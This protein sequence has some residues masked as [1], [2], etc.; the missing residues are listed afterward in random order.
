[1]SLHPSL[2]KLEEFRGQFPTLA[3]FLGAWFPD[4]DLEGLSDAEVAKA[5][6]T[7]NDVAATHTI[8][9]EGRILLDREEFPWREVGTE[10]NRSFV[11]PSEARNWLIYILNIIDNHIKI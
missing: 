5:F 7:T 2:S 6:V 10:A 9:S 8:L 11:E 3:N 4:A 1:M